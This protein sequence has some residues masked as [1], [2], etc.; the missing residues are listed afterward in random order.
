MSGYRKLLCPVHHYTHQVGREC[1]LC[2]IQLPEP[3]PLQ[4]WV[5]LTWSELGKRWMMAD[6]VGRV[7]YT[8]I[9]AKANLRDIN[10]ARPKGE[11]CIKRFVEFTGEQCQPTKH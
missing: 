4:L 6:H 8:E 9:T 11:H 1:P 5:L 3:S 10:Q 2:V 7:S